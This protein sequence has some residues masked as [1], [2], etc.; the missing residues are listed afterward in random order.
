MLSY[1]KVIAFAGNKIIVVI[2]KHKI[3]LSVIYENIKPLLTY[4]YI[5][6]NYQ[7]DSYIQNLK[8]AASAK[9]MSCKACYSNLTIFTADNLSQCGFGNHKALLGFEIQIRRSILQ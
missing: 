3:R 4:K 6:T 8:N 2:T 1:E 5:Y 9:K 7:I